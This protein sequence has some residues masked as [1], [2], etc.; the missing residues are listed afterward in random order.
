M[1]YIAGSLLALL[2]VSSTSVDAGGFYKQTFVQ[3]APP[4]RSLLT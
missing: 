2:A 4:L 1:K 3:H